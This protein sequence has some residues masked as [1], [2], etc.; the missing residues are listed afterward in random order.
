MDQQSQTQ[1]II[2]AIDELKVLSKNDLIEQLKLIHQL[3]LKEAVDF[4]KKIAKLE[5]SRKQIAADNINQQKKILSMEQVLKQK[6]IKKD[7]YKSKYIKEHQQ[8]LK[9]SQDIKQLQNSAF[10]TQELVKQ[11]EEQ[12]VYLIKL[13]DEVTLQ[14][15]RIQQQI[16]QS[17]LNFKS[18]V[19]DL[20]DSFFSSD[21]DKNRSE[22]IHSMESFITKAST[23]ASSETSRKSAISGATYNKE[24]I[25]SLETI[26]EDLQEKSSSTASVVSS[27]SDLKNTNISSEKNLP[28]QNDP[29]EFNQ[30]EIQTDR[31]TLIGTLESSSSTHKSSSRSKEELSSQNSIRPRNAQK[32]EFVLLVNNHIKD[33]VQNLKLNDDLSVIRKKLDLQFQYNFI[34]NNNDSSKNDQIINQKEE[35][36]YNLNQIV[37]KKHEINVV[38]SHPSYFKQL[39]VP[40]Q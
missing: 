39:I 15:L 20:K 10:Q 8:M 36:N 9:L 34:N 38:T 11:K 16:E 31:S 12:E 2:T 26:K 23:F 22:S 4:E 24:S 33:T 29:L 37:N 32:E 25:H 40:M 18:Q 7:S 19:Q 17:I 6:K 1:K 35:K 27:Q 5:K 3:K 14:N 13:I 30:E 28:Q 21:F